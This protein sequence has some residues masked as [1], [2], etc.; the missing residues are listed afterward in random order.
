MRAGQEKAPIPASL[1][2]NGIGAGTT[3][4]EANRH[5]PNSTI[6]AALAIEAS[7]YAVMIIAARHFLPAPLARC[8]AELALIGG[9]S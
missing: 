6:T 5:W 3:G 2:A 7:D 8:V 4:G 1:A 9:L